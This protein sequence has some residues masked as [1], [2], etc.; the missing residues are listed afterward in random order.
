VIFLL[1]HPLMK[2]YVATNLCSTS[3]MTGLWQNV[4]GQREDSQL[5]EHQMNVFWFS[6]DSCDVSRTYSRWMRKYI[7]YCWYWRKSD[8]GRDFFYPLYT[9]FVNPIILSHI[10]KSYLTQFINLIICS[11]VRYDTIRYVLM[12]TKY[13]IQERNI[14]DDHLLIQIS[15]VKHFLIT[16]IAPIKV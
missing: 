15:V 9:A 1:P 12:V 2:K 3:S 14:E 6:F 16:L 8:G 11:T 5:S 7:W 13:S 10:T 4:T